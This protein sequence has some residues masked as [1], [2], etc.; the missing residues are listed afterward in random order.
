MIWIA[1][2]YFV[3]QFKKSSH[4]I[5]IVFW[6][7][8]FQAYLSAI[9]VYLYA[10]CYKDAVV[11]HR[12][13]SGYCSIFALCSFR[14]SKWDPKQKKKQNWSIG[15]FIIWSS[16][17]WKELDIRATSHTR[18]RAHDHCTLIVGKGGASPSSLHTK[19][20]GPTKYVNARWM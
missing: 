12:D 19:L 2:A 17:Y 4:F 11:C 1:C 10:D 15:S 7:F 6:G 20:E 16:R 8:C 5:S 18:L 9:I 3:L 14:R 13:C